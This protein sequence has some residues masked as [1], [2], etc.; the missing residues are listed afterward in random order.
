MNTPAIKIVGAGL[1][2]TSLGLAL[3]KHG[4]TAGLTDQSK[5]NLRLAIEY[6]AG[7]EASAEPD[8]IIVCVPPDLT[9]EVVARELSA[10][11]NATVTDV[12]STKAE[13]AT[14]VQELSIEHSRY[15]GSHPMAGREK[16]GPG[17]ARADLFFARP[18]VIT[19]NSDTDPARLEQVRDLALRLGALPKVM[20][21]QEHD[22]AVAMVSH[23]P[24][25]AAS[26]TAA[27]LTEARPEQL[28][29]A[30]QGLRDTTRIAASD[31]DLW[32]QILS[33]NSSEVAPLLK[34]LASDLTELSESLEN[35]ELNGSLAK[36]H[37]LLE[38]G[39]QGASKIPGKHGGKYAEYELVTVIIDD[40]PGALA[41]LLT[42]IGA[43][44]VNIEDLKLEHS[45][46]AE[47]GLVELQVLPRSAKQLIDSLTEAGWRLV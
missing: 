22:A 20:T 10:H 44:D 32:I 35:P 19:T 46:G 31:P 18:W 12:A 34:L 17:K 41:S 16:G 26:L 33:Q 47:I 45:P 11:P 24:Q 37:A 7:V 40:S 30:G 9:A 5:A 13:I 42:F 38:R 15:I 29:L 2:G 8:L 28:E 25:L 3:K 4:I 14:S 36:L 43:I 6:G 23:L 39:N 1:L 27:R 21:T